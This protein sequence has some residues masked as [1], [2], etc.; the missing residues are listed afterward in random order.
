[1]SDNDALVEKISEV[2][3]RLY[4]TTSDGG[5]HS[6]EDIAR[7]VLPLVEA[8]VTWLTFDRDRLWGD[9]KALAEQVA[10]TRRRAEAAEAESERLAEQVSILKRECTE[11]ERDAEFQ[12]QTRLEAEER[13]AT[14]LG[15]VKDGLH[16]RYHGERA[17]SG[18]E[19][20]D[21]WDRNAEIAVRSASENA[22]LDDLAEEHHHGIAAALRC[23]REAALISVLSDWDDEREV[24][25]S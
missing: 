22:E 16:L 1:M 2:I 12:L 13:K 17:P 18:D 8:E 15:I 10:D 24:G 9:V 25:K 5:V 19:T 7:A 14:L 6:T 3:E 11:L 4:L 23:E 20:W 21:E